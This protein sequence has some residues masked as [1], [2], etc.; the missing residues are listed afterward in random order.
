MVEEDDD[1][2]SESQFQ[3]P[4][5]RERLDPG[6]SLPRAKVAKSPNGKKGHHTKSSE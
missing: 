4:P 1:L 2:V 5:G 6:H 3:D